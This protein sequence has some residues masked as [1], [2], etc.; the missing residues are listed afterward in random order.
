MLTVIVSAIIVVVALLGSVLNA[1]GIVTPFPRVITLAELPAPLAPAA[2]SRVTVDSGGFVWVAQSAP[3]LAGKPNDQTLLTIVDPT[4]H[5]GDRVQARLCLGCAGVAGGVGMA[6]I[7]DI[8]P[9]PQHLHS[10]YV[11]GWSAPQ[12]KA[13]SV[14][15]VMAV[16]WHSGAASCAARRTC[17]DA[18]VL[19]TSTT[20]VAFINTPTDPDKPLLQQYLD[21]GAA[22]VLSLAT[23]S[24][25]DL[26]CF[27]SDR[28][29]DSLSDA[30]TSITGGMQMLLKWD[31]DG[32][33]WGEVYVGPAGRRMTQTLSPTSTVSALAVDRAERY[34]Y[35]A[36]SD[37]QAIY[38]MDLQNSALSSPSPYVAASAVTR[39]AGQALA[40]GAYGDV[41]QAAPGWTGDG[42]P[43]I[44][45]RLN[46]PRGLAF[47]PHGDLLVSD[48]GND[49]V[50]LIAPQGTIWTVAGR[51]APAVDGDTHA[52]LQ[53]GLRGILGIAANKA[54]DVYV[55]QG[56][57]TDGAG[58]VR[59]RALSWGW[60][61]PAA[62]T[63]RSP[64]GG[65]GM[66][67]EAVAGLAAHNAQ[68]QWATLIGGC[69]T[70]F[71]NPFPSGAREGASRCATAYQVAAGGALPD[72][73]ALALPSAMGETALVGS[74]SMLAAAAPGTGIVIIADA[75]PAQIAFAPAYPGSTAATLPA[76]I[77]LPAGARPT[78]LAVLMPVTDAQASYLGAAYILVAVQGSGPAQLLIYKAAAETCGPQHASN[79]THFPGA[80]ALAATLSFAGQA[81]T[82]AVAGMLSDDGRH[83]IVLVAHPAENLVSAIDLTPWFAHATPLSV[84]AQ[85]PVQ[86]PGDIA[87][88]HD[89]MAAYIGASGGQIAVLPTTGW[90]SGGIPAQPVSANLVA[91]GDASAQGQ[92]LALAGDDSRLFAA[93]QAPS[94]SSTIVSADIGNFGQPAAPHAL[95]SFAAE[96][97]LAALALADGDARLLATSTPNGAAQP[98]TLHAWATRDPANPTQ[99]L[100]APLDLGTVATGADPQ[101]LVAE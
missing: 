29:R 92:H 100:A 25:G 7:D 42:G 46:A 69:A 5:F 31:R 23:A 39:Y 38:R 71:P 50:R 3:G 2:Y 61:T 17:A 51:G 80:P 26:F 94:A 58:K 56:A 101:A 60:F 74:G 4:L 76:P 37:H 6:R 20:A 85:I 10:I 14:P 9:D 30:E 41:A 48:A 22:P 99:W 35:L 52:P 44:N 84:G 68:A 19:L 32:Q 96:K 13:A 49:R 95:A 83:A 78:G 34:I 70:L 79:C 88:R 93:L 98:G 12:G 43:A 62:N 16:N 27:L 86:S 65:Q 75:N 54:G 91:L 72:Q 28:G 81:S 45:A 59:L 57:A 55:I 64:S 15:V 66:A 24:N 11:A 1:L 89:G 73:A 82:G 97:H 47:D 87:L 77:A 36:D 67:A 40:S 21:I 53:A 8:A 18:S 33:S 90:L 63:T